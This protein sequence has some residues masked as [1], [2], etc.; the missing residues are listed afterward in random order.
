MLQLA[1]F[2]LLWIQEGDAK[3]LTLRHEAMKQQLIG[4]FGVAHLHVE[5]SHALM[6]VSGSRL[7][8]MHELA[9]AHLD[10]VSKVC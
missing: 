4:S 8:V 9:G 5:R 1:G 7:I 3:T 10:R 2:N 6:P